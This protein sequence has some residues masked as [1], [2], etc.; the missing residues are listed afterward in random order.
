MTDIKINTTGVIIPDT[1]DIYNKIADEWN[2][3]FGGKMQ[4]DPST[5]QGQM[6]TSLVA[7]I[8]NKNRLLNYFIN[9]INPKTNEGIWQDAI[10]D[11]FF[12]ER[13]G[14]ESSSVVC[15]CTGLAGTI[16]PSGS[17]VKSS[18]GDLFSAVGNITI[19]I[20]GTA[21]GTFGSVDKGL[22]PV[23]SN[24]INEIVS[25]ISGWDSVN[26]ISA[27]SIGRL[28]ETRLEFEERRKKSVA[29]NSKS[30]IASLYARLGDIV[31]VLDVYC[32][33]NRENTQIQKD[34]IV[35]KPHSVYCCV[36]GGLTEDIATVIENT[37]SAGDDTTGNTS[38]NVILEENGVEDIINFQRPN[39][40]DCKIIVNLQS[41][42]TTP[43]GIQQ[44][45]K[46]IIFDDFYGIDGDTTRVGIGETVYA[47]RFYRGIA[48]IEGI[49]IISIKIDTT[50][51]SGEDYVYIP[52]HQ[53]GALD[54]NNIEV[55]I[56]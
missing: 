32:I 23:V 33:S 15:Q 55:N 51:G 34:T 39:P 8:D 19:N 37:I 31:N 7:E 36:L 35:I 21:D 13:K 28:E 50:S 1:E 30:T 17:L 26:N 41:T 42:S 2:A 16:I 27:G 25:T 40:F 9:Q 49:S 56:L 53:Y 29:K 10:A 12:L 47:S 52:I 22:I 24:T 43:V 3:I 38:Y 4:T 44:K 20:N 54:K 6:I 14:A 46:D 45:I 48:E 18:N 11:I 5:P